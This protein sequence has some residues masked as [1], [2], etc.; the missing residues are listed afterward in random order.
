MI[1]SLFYAQPVPKALSVI[2]VNFCVTIKI[3]FIS[4]ISAGLKN[5]LSLGCL[6]IFLYLCTDNLRCQCD[7]GLRLSNVRTSR[8]CIRLAPQ[9][10]MPKNILFFY[11]IR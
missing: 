6:R 2:S 3:S 4:F 9:L 1:A 7:C 11:G 10:S 8:R 5:T